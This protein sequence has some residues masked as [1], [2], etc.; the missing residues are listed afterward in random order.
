MIGLAQSLKIIKIHI[1]FLA[2]VVLHDLASACTSDLILFSFPLALCVPPS[3][4]IFTPSSMPYF[5]YLCFFF[6]LLAFALLRDSMAE[7]LIA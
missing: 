3:Q 2:V 5:F 7:W 1:K 4:A 6:S